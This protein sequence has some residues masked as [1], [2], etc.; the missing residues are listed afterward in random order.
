MKLDYCL[1]VPTI[2]LREIYTVICTIGYFWLPLHR[3]IFLTP[4]AATPT[5]TVSDSYHHLHPV[6]LYT[7]TSEVNTVAVSNYPRPSTNLD[8]IEHG[9]D[10]VQSTATHSSV[11]YVEHNTLNKHDRDKVIYYLISSIV[12]NDTS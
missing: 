2:C 9:M 10:Y 6:S 1:C 3:I 7:T 5:V 4:I 8:Q 12:H 11:L